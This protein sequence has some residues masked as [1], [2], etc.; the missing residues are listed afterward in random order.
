M[1]D[2]NYRRGVFGEIIDFL[3]DPLIKSYI[4]DENLDAVYRNN[5]IRNTSLLTA[6][7]EEVGVDPLEYVTRI[8]SY[9]YEGCPH[10]RLIIPPTITKIDHYAFS[11]DNLEYIEIQNDRCDIADCA[12]DN[13]DDWVKI[14]CRG[15]TRTVAGK[16]ICKGKWKK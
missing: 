13:L 15:E 3:D 14:Y 12:F 10:K 4:E 2:Y 7:L 5:S 8:I 11:G 9:M 16:L 1:P 6:Y